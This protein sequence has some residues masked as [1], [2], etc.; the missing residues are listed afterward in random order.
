MAMAGIA[1]TYPVM[2]YT[3]MAS[4]FMAYIAMACI[5]MVGYIGIADR[6]R[7]AQR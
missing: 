3:V 2:A 6:T 7:S 4:I 5:V 1:V